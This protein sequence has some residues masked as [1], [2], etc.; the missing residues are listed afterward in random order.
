MFVN[1]EPDTVLRWVNCTHSI[2]V[3]KAREVI[4]FVLDKNPEDTELADFFLPTGYTVIK[5]PPKEKVQKKEIEQD[6]IRLA[7][8]NGLSLKAIEEAYKDG[9]IEKSEY[10]KIKRLLVQVRRLAAELIE[11]IGREAQ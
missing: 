3:D 7:I 6:E 8:L 10:N 9:R 11:K 2:P 4:L 5:E 1:R